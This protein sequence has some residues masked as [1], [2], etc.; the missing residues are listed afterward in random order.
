MYLKL[1]FVFVWWDFGGWWVPPRTTPF[2]WVWSATKGRKVSE[3]RELVRFN[4]QNVWIAPQ[5]PRLTN[6]Q[7]QV[8][9]T[10]FFS[11]FTNSLPTSDR[12]YLQTQLKIIDSCSST[13]VL[14]SN[15]T[16]PLSLEKRKKNKKNK[17]NYNGKY[18]TKK[19][20]INISIPS[21]PN[22]KHIV[23]TRIKC[24]KLKGVW[25]SIWGRCGQ[26]MRREG[27]NIFMIFKWLI[28][29]LISTSKQ[30]QHFLLIYFTI[31]S[32]LNFDTTCFLCSLV[33]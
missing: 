15:P 8:P 28:I 2:V 24:V 31:L 22:S 5:Q 32:K 14:S 20:P 29:I 30:S 17:R 33:S 18:P 7:V 6:S 11:P 13:H 26:S 21:C 23:L 19:Y 4:F 1:V 27:D 25:V 10:H 12:R 16:F 3:S 9:S